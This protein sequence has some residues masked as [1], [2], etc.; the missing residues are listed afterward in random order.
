MAHHLNKNPPWRNILKHVAAASL[1][2]PS[3][4]STCPVNILQ[5][6]VP[7]V[8]KERIKEAHSN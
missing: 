3:L 8:E 2:D 4:F 1:Q 6:T 7:Q 5:G